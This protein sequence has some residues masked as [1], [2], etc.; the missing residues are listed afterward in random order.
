MPRSRA[1]GDP[2]RRGEITVGKPVPRAPGSRSAALGAVE[3]LG[4][5][6]VGGM[7]RRDAD[8]FERFR[9]RMGE[10]LAD[11]WVLLSNTDRF[12][13]RAG[14]MPKYERQLRQW[15]SDLQSAGNDIDRTRD[16]RDEIIAF[17]KSRRN[18]GWELRLGS[19]DIQVKGF[20]SDDAMGVGF[21]RMVLYVGEGGDIRYIA[22]SANHIQLDEEMNVRFRQTPPTEPLEPHY[23]WYRKVDDVLE[24]AGADSQPKESQERLIDYVE[25]HKSDLVR[26][27]YKLS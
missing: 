3:S 2:F 4:D 25:R 26:A 9:S 18:E 7:F 14:L 13:S 1:A 10:K 16:I 24:L 12:V 27:L 17:R 15:R 22:G 11:A 20:R 8:L 5:R 23:L 19:L 6:P 21:R